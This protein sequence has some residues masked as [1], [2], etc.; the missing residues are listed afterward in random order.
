MPMPTP[1]AANGPMSTTDRAP[2]AEPTVKPI[3]SGEPRALRDTDWKIAPDRPR[4]APTTRA[5]SMRGSR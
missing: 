1:V 3:I 2:V 5:A 4:A